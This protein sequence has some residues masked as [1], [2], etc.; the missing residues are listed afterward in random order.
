MKTREELEKEY[1]WADDNQ[2]YEIERGI[3]EWI[4][5]YNFYSNIALGAK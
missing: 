3:Q 4:K 1:S 2:L 5:R